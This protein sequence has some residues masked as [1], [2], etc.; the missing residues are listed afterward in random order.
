MA[1][2]VGAGSGG[3]GVR[4]IMAGSAR[5]GDEAEGRRK[6]DKANDDSELDGAVRM[7]SGLTVARG[8]RSGGLGTMGF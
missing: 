6:P 3:R 2:T 7:G 4:G 1:S 5:G 8:G